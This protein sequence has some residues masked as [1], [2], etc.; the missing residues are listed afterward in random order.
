MNEKLSLFRRALRQREIEAAIILDE[1]NIGYLCE[2]FFTD[3]LLYIDSGTA[4]LITDSRYTEEAEKKASDEFTVVMPSDRM[5]FLRDVLRSHQIR[6]LGY[7]SRT[8]T[9]E[10]YHSYERGLSVTFRPMSDIL[11]ELR[12]VKTEDEISRIKRA[13]EITDAAYSHILKMLH[14]GMTEVDVALELS[15]FMQK[16]G[17]EDKSFDIIAVSGEASAYPHGHARNMPLSAGFLTMDFGCIY[18]NYCS[19]M[20]RTVVIGKADAEMKRLYQTVLTAQENALSAIKEGITCAAADGFAR[21]YI[22]RAGY[23][24]TFGHGL[25]HGV[26]LNIHEA[27][28]LSPHAK[29]RRLVRGNVITVEPGIY[30]K[31][32]YGCRIEDMGA[33]TV[34]GFDNFTKSTKELIELF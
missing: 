15:Y 12:A 13:Q 9:V 28:S 33:V 19:D 31:G 8:M 25:G 27:P 30:L 4:Y 34:C 6:T 29:E 5:A 10:Q 17:A 14:P 2:Y 7:E 21:Q 11:C 24:G 20:T 18:Q 22:D 16:N 32:K 26:G 23:N 3:G 1:K